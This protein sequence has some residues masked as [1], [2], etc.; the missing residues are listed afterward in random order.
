MQITDREW[1]QLSAYLDGELSGR[2]LEQVRKRLK[3]DPRLQDAL[4]QLQITKQILQGAPVLKA[5]RNFTLT[6]DMVGQKQKKPA[7]AGF[8]LAAALMSVLLIG[9]L[10][11]DFGRFLAIGAMAPAA[12][13]YQ[14]VMLEAMPESAADAVEEPA[15]MKAESEV[16]EVLVGADSEKSVLGEADEAA[17]GV[18]GCEAPPIEDAADQP[19]AE[20]EAVAESL[21]AEPMEEPA[22]AEGTAEEESE[23]RAHEPTEGENLVEEKEAPQPTSQMLPTQ[24]V[25]PPPATIEYFSE[26][27]YEPTQEPGIPIFRILEI[28]LAAGVIGFS[29]AAWLRRRK[30]SQ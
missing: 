5:P 13:K 20:A 4:K 12:P 29:A 18:E 7:A 16:D 10:I 14:E 21:S 3:S 2:E 22:P 28:L 27:V 15:L 24:T 17:A 30:N 19:V 23:Q 11:M 25:E 26:D 8:R 1:V 9:V 6:P